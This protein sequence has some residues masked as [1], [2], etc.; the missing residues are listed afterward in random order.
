MLLFE[1]K[2]MASPP[3]EFYVYLTNK[4]AYPFGGA[5][6]TPAVV[7]AS[8]PTPMDLSNFKYEMALVE[9]QAPRH[10][11]NV[12]GCYYQIF[13]FKSHGAL[14][15]RTLGIPDNYYKNFE[16][17]FK[18]FT[19][20]TELKENRIAPSP[21]ATPIAA[22]SFASLYKD[23]NNYY[24]IVLAPNGALA[25]SNRF[26][27]LLGLES[28]SYT[29]PAE[30]EGERRI[31]IFP[32]LF[33]DQYSAM[34]KCSLLAPSFVE[35]RTDAILRIFSTVRL[36]QNEM[37]NLN[38]NPIYV[39]VVTNRLDTIEIQLTDMKG[40]V[41]KTFQGEIVVLIHLR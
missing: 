39:P 1:P 26:R 14:K 22:S 12:T 23:S 28:T 24:N 8:L 40:K 11:F 41:I 17:I 29:H 27:Q 15:T 34:A 20:Q 13:N 35:N 32:N 9:I 10:W 36:D 37:L 2:N 30:Q 16:E 6:S 25:L 33:L 31:R 4:E 19:K 3:T 5:A 18:I 38:F 21:G 7:K